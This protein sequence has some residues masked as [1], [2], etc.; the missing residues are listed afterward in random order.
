[1]SSR[2]Y[3]VGQIIDDLDAI[4]SQ[5]RQRCKLGQTDLNTVLEDFF[6]ELLNLV[7]GINLR[8]LN[9]ERINEPGVDLG[10]DDPSARIAFQI[11]SQA[12]SAK[13]NETLKKITAEQRK[14][15][16][17]FKVLIIGQ[18]Q[19]K[20]TLNSAL[21]SKNNFKKDDI[22]GITEL[23]REIMD[24]ELGDLQAVH[25]KVSDEQ[26]RIRIELEPELPDGTFETSVLKYIEGRPSITRSSASEFYKHPDVAD[27][28]ENRK[29]AQKALNSY[30]DELSRLPRMTREFLGWMIDDADLTDSSFGAGGLK[31]NADYVEAKCR[32]MPNYMSEIRLLSA[33][34]FIDYDREEEHVS[35]VFQI[36]FPGAEKTNFGEAFAY[37]HNAQSLTAS[38]LF[39][40]MNF[41][42]FGPSLKEKKK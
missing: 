19:K 10:D 33:R 22:L 42:P 25:R 37:F 23:C 34:D 39:S 12:S 32:N 5:V 28:F 29:E 7:Y 27:L 35:G 14:S 21:A 8:N 24:L 41:S 18:K 11:T 36:Y 1:M 26:R 9:K 15:Y 13:V 38:T 17:K 20:Y 31:I 16:G 6:K 30:I 2:G 4:A 3:F 40:T